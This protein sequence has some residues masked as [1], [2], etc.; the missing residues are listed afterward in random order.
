MENPVARPRSRSDR[1]CWRRGP[2]IVDPISV[3]FPQASSRCRPGADSVLATPVDV[4]GRSTTLKLVLQRR[5]IGRRV[6]VAIS[7]HGSRGRARRRRCACCRADCVG[8]VSALGD[9]PR[10]DVDGCSSG[11][12]LRIESGRVQR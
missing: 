2:R 5:T 8:A 12:R 11:F 1:P 10:H 4:M 9:V 3:S 7:A 6:E